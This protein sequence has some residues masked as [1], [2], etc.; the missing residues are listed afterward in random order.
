METL[1]NM[2][3]RSLQ[4]YVIGRQWASDLEFF[5]IETAFLH[6]LLEDYFVGLLNE[7]HLQQLKHAGLNLF[8]LEKDETELSKMLDEQIKQL[9]LM[10]EDVIPENCEELAGK[11]AQLENRVANLMHKYRSVKKE[12]FELVEN[13]MNVK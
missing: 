8:Y 4:Y 12:I 3:A 6:R 5:R 2:S 7:M 9:E 10:A 13:V 11:Q 1:N